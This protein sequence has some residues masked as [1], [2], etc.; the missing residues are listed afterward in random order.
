[1]ISEKYE[2][3]TGEYEVSQK[4]QELCYGQ[5]IVDIKKESDGAKLILVLSNGVELI[6]ESNEGCGGC[7]NGWFEYEDV[8]VLGTA[9]NIITKIGVECNYDESR[10]CGS[11][12]L[13]VYSL[14]KRIIKAD[15]RGEDNGYYGIGIYISVYVPDM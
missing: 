14:D 7:G 13:H 8:I 2:Y 4:I 12:N 9:G 5:S 15:F 10:D 11:F 3:L 6:A 1:M